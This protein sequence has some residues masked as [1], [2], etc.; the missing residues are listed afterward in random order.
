MVANAQ[1]LASGLDEVVCEVDGRE[2][3][4]AP[5]GY[6]GKCLHW[7]REEYGALAAGDRTRVDVVLA[8]TGCEQLFR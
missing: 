5:F 8:G 2:Y 6:Q 7:L 1:A 4:Q 3:R